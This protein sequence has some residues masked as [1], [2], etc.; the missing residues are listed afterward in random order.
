MSGKITVDSK[1]LDEILKN[2]ELFVKKSVPEMVRKYSRLCAVELANRTQPFSVGTGAGKKAEG[3]GKGAV[4]KGVGT[5]I[6]GPAA[7][8]LIVDK[9]TS[10]KLKAQLQGHLTSNNMKAFGSALK[11]VGMYKDYEM[12]SKSQL[13][14][15]HKN[16]RSKKTGRSYSPKKEF[17]TAANLGAYIK[18]VQK[19]VGLSKSGWADCARKIG[20]IKGDGA[21]GIPAFAKA[22][23]HGSHGHVTFKLKGKNPSIAMRNDIPWI[24]RICP[25]SEQK[26]ALGIA[27][28]KMIKEMN[29]RLK[30]ATKNNFD[31]LKDE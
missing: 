16:H 30:A 29:Q 28:D 1:E 13:G 25:S 23:R 7:L 10:E 27:K 11:A 14:D 20:G 9:T 17:L 22:K 2:H 12:L 3:L 26:K 8:Q 21:R 15:A 24:S 5:V 18:K 19:R 4:D 6:A 31:P